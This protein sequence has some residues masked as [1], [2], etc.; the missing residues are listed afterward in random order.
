MTAAAE[1]KAGEEV[2]GFSSGVLVAV[3]SGSDNGIAGFPEVVCDKAFNWAAD[4]FFFWFQME[5][6]FSVAVGVVSA[7]DPF[8]RSIL[9]ETDD[10][11]IGEFGAVTGSISCV[12]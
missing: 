4:P 2:D 9:D 6:S 3:F 11:C 1:E 7:I 10:S 12:V 5:L 8:R